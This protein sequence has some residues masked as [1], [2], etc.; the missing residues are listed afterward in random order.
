MSEFFLGL[1]GVYGD[2][3]GVMCFRCGMVGVS[4]RDSAW[5]LV[6]VVHSGVFYSRERGSIGSMH[7]TWGVLNSK[8]SQQGR[9]AG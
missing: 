1:C 7:G 9:V 2:G 4:G 8:G 3:T 6:V 5:S